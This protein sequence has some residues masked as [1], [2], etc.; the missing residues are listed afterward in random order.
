MSRPMLLCLVA[1]MASSAYAA[2][3]PKE[4]ANALKDALKNYSV[5]LSMPDSPGL[6]IVGLNS[7]QVLRPATPRAL[8]MAV[9]QGRNADGSLKQGLAIDFAPMKL[10]VPTMTKTEY[11]GSPWVARP[12]WNTQISLGVG[13]PLSDADKSTR[14]G[15]GLSSVLWRSE[16][17]DPLLDQK[18]A[19]CL[20]KVLLSRQPSTMP[21]LDGAPPPPPPKA[22]P[23]KPCYDDLEA[24]TWNS[25]ALMVGLAAAHLSGRDPNVLPDASPRGYWVSY[26]YGFEG[27]PSLQ[28]YLQFTA[29]FR[30][31]RE[32][33]VADPKDD[34]KFV[35]QDSKLVGL[36]LYGKSAVANLFIEASRKRATIAGR[37]TEH[38]DLFVLGAERKLT[39]NLWLTLSLGKQRGG[40]DANPV[41]V[42]TGLKFGYETEASIK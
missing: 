25:S 18:H 41:Y 11:A 31:L 21:P 9:L 22:L 6:S 15:L 19:E 20:D 7:E 26:N 27:V 3:A 23:L 29:S 30:S 32:E 42:S 12:L 8:G 14:I 10:L 28:P 39:D 34:T 24:R 33:I 13:Q 17:S 36:K 4:D 38:T 1:C 40:T 16:A 37:D 2:D 5:D 35:E